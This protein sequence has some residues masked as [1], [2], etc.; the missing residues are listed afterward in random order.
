MLYLQAGKPTAKEIAAFT[1]VLAEQGQL[2]FALSK[3]TVWRCLTAPKLPPNP[4]DP[5]ALAFALARMAQMDADEVQQRIRRL[6]TDERLHPTPSLRSVSY[7]DP[8]TELGVHSVIEIGAAGTGHGVKELTSYVERAHD[9]RLHERLRLARDEGHAVFCLLVGESSVGKTRAMY[10]AVAACLPDWPLLVPANAEQLQHWITQDAIDPQTVLWLNETQRFLPSTGP[11]LADLLRRARALAVIGSMWPDYWKP[12]LAPPD[13]AQGYDEQRA[14]TRTLIDLHRPL[15]PVVENFNEEQRSELR[16]FSCTDGR[17]AAALK[18]GAK[19][20]RIT[21]HLTGGPDLISRYEQGHYSPLEHAVITAALD[22]RRLG[23]KSAIPAVLLAEAAE[24]YLETHQCIVDEPNWIASVLRTLCGHPHQ[25]HG[26]LT[27]ITEA[28]IADGLGPADGYHPADYLDQ[29]ARRTR[30]TRVP[31]EPFWSSLTRH[32]RTPEDLVELGHS[33]RYRGRWRIAAD[34]YQHAADLGDSGGLRLIGLIDRKMS[35]GAS[36]IE[37]DARESSTSPA[38]RAEETHGA[39]DLLLREANTEAVPK[40]PNSI[41]T[42]NPEPHLTLECPEGEFLNGLQNACSGELK[43]AVTESVKAQISAVKGEM[44]TG[45]EGL[46]LSPVDHSESSESGSG[47]LGVRVWLM[48]SSG[49]EAEAELL[50][51]DAAETGDTFPAWSL[52][53][54]RWEA[55]DETGALR[56]ARKVGDSTTIGDL[57][58]SLW[59]SGREDE[60]ECLAREAAEAGDGW[61]LVE[62]ALLADDNGDRDKALRLAREAADAGPADDGLIFLLYRQVQRGQAGEWRQAVQYGL[63]ADGRASRPWTLQPHVGGHRPDLP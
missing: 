28:R 2:V 31:P 18:A 51:L 15:I 5:A 48:W 33:A 63:E 56:F 38:M 59:E 26:A 41:S 14:A 62:L 6:W 39:P 35:E 43:H 40:E 60:A 34:L 57:A 30:G 54:L 46:T 7:W 27:P 4:E 16:K 45:L 25:V 36:F 13:T 55:G 12:L 37:G 47:Q 32:A 58:E 8:V 44:A 9:Q 20:G 21:Q 3:D 50:A 19:D 23:H 53:M 52:A 11:A 1:D 61:P 42:N 10:E 24:A 49:E 17:L 22:A 29:H